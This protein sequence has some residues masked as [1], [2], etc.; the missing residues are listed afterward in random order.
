M[1]VYFSLIAAVLPIMGYLFFIW[2][3]DRYDREPFGLLFKNFTWGAVGAVFFAFICNSIFSLIVSAIFRDRKF[4][5]LTS[6]IIGAPV[7]EEIAKGFFLFITI[8]NK[9]FDNFTDGIVYGGAIGLG[10]GM[11]ENFLYFLSYGKDLN[12][13]I[14]IVFVR[15][16]FSAV[17]HCVATAVFGAFLGYAKYKSLLHKIIAVPAGL[18]LAMF[19]HF[20]WNFSV[21]FQATSVVGFI[22]MIMTISIFILAFKLAIINE[23]R[24]IFEEL[25]DE[26][27]LG[28][29]PDGHLDIIAF[30]RKGLIDGINP[31]DKNN[32]LKSAVALAF[33][34]R[35]LNFVGARQKAEFQNEVNLLRTKISGYLNWNSGE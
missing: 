16:M 25:S 21:S 30:N 12:S 23:R 4:A 29:L 14:N 11:T 33:K 2:K 9:N 10:F 35:Q 19:I 7:I 13:W 26:V 5:D 27:K 32:Y 15:T 18:A 28:F 1:P 20:A 17:M 6:T 34:K 31:K 3:F 24:L 8:S 22:F